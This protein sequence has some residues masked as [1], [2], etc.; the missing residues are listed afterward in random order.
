M[1]RT[2]HRE[3]LLYAAC[4]EAKQPVVVDNTNA[5]AALRAGYIAQA[6]TAGFRVAGYYFASRASECLL[7]NAARPE[8]E[9]VPDTA[10]LGTAGA[11]ERPMRSEGYDAL[12]YVRLAADGFAVE[13]WSD[14]VR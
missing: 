13:E 10:V 6:R 11:L 12:Y 8:D 9:R 14:E 2:R 7:R 5:T 1:L 4:I 3:R